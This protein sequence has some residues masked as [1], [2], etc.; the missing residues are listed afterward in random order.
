MVQIST[1]QTQRTL[2]TLQPNKVPTMKLAS[3][4]SAGRG[5]PAQH[6]HYQLLALLGVGHAIILLRRDA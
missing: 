2:L 6:K 1:L 4:L 5:R 3:T